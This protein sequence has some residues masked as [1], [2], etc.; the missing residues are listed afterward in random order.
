MRWNTW[1][2]QHLRLV[3]RHRSDQW[4]S[5]DPKSWVLTMC[6]TKPY[7][8]IG[9]SSRWSQEMFYQGK[10]K[11][12]HHVRRSG[13]KKIWISLERRTWD[14]SKELEWECEEGSWEILLLPI[15]IPSLGWYFK[16]PWGKGEVNERGEGVFHG[17][18]RGGML[19]D[20]RGERRRMVKSSIFLLWAHGL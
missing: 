17:F 16:S 18:G 2:N 10:F 3:T 9:M 8:S 15:L 1:G 13:K 12:F 11:S 6:P 14:V 4:R 20:D 19:V 5:Y 7:G